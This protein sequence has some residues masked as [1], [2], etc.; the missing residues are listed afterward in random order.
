MS[1]TE[2][3]EAIDP[4][5]AGTFVERWT[6]VWR[7]HDAERWQELIHESGVLRNPLGELKWADLPSY[8]AG[9]AASIGD[10]RITPLRW[11][12]TEDGVLI[13]WVMTGSARGTRFEIHGADRFTLRDGRAVE[14]AAYFDP[15]PL[16]ETTSSDAAEQE[17]E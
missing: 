17:E 9:L 4:G 8:M 13:E 3:R 11:G 12:A 14:G 15:R 6:A 10:H 1:K 2:S 7:D 5:Q 16:F